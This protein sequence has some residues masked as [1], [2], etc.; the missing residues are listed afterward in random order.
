MPTV[1][2]NVFE[3]TEPQVPTIYDVTA[4]TYQDVVS[5][6]M[7]Y[8]LFSG[9]IYGVNGEVVDYNAPITLPE[10]NYVIPAGPPLY[11]ISVKLVSK[12]PTQVAYST[13]QRKSR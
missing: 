9:Q 4:D 12:T 3:G 2:V 8:G 5:A 13:R 10:V 7:N 6:L 11:Q 1:R